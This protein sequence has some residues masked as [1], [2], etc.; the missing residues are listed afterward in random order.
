[1]ESQGGILCPDDTMCYCRFVKTVVDSNLN[2][3]AVPTKAMQ[4]IHPYMRD[5][6]LVVTV[7]H[8]SL[9]DVTSR[10]RNKMNARAISNSRIVV[11]LTPR[12][13]VNLKPVID[14]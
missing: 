14:R 5:S 12:L 2:D 4:F 1:M 8:R 3:G 13:H 7:T 10:T 9:P 6:C 11:L